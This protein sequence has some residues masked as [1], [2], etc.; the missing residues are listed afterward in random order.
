MIDTDRYEGHSPGPWKLCGV[1]SDGRRIE[2]DDFPD[3]DKYDDDWP[4]LDIVSENGCEI[5]EHVGFSVIEP[6]PDLLLMVDAPLLLD[7]YKDKCEEV[8]RLRYHLQKA[9]ELLEQ[10]NENGEGEYYW[11]G[12]EYRFRYEGEEE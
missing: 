8:K 7:A 1:G 3:G 5:Q 4:S 12:E 2:Y 11:D 9:E 10:W 6:G